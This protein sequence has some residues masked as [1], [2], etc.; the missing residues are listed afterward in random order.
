MP[1]ILL[2]EDDFPLLR[3]LTLNLARRGYT[4]AEANSMATGYEMALVACEAGARF[5]LIIIETHLP[6]GSGWDML[7]RL[8]AQAPRN[9]SWRPTPVIV[10]SPLPVA[11]SRMEEFAPVA[12]LPKPFP[13]EALLRLVERAVAT[14]EAPQPDPTTVSA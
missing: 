13:I 2:V 4:V 12:A 10:I 7:R 3:T 11:R 1:R 5:D 14:T 6:D 8:R 9:P